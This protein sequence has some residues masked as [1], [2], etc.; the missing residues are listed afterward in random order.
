MQVLAK[1]IRIFVLI[2][3]LANA[4]SLAQET[5]KAGE[6]R[7]PIT[8]VAEDDFPRGV[9]RTRYWIDLAG[10]KIELHFDGHPPELTSGQIA[11]VR[12]V[13]RGKQIDAAL[14]SVTPAAASSSCG[15]IGEQKMAVL[16]IEFPGIPFPTSIVTATQ[17]H[18][19]YFSQTQFSLDGYWREASYGQTFATG[20]VFGPFLLDKNYDFFADQFGGLQA[21]INA[22]DSAV[23]FTV[24][25][26]VVV[27][28]PAPGVSGWGGRG[29]VGCLTL[30]SPTKGS[31][32]GTEAIM[33]VGTAQPYQGLVGLAAHEAG[34][35]LGLN[36]ASTLDYEPL[37]LGP[38]GMDGVHKEYGD[39]FSVMGGGEGGRVLGHYGAPHKYKLGWLDPS[40]VTNVETDGS[41]TLQPFEN[42]T[43]THTLRIQRGAGSTQW[44]WLEYRRPTGYDA[45]LSSI[46]AEEFAGA[47][48]HLEDPAEEPNHTYLLDFTPNTPHDFSDAAL[49]AGQVWSD[50][51]SPLSIRVDSADSSGLGVSVSYS[52]PCAT[53]NP[54]SRSHGS[55]AETGMFSVTASST[56]SWTAIS[57]IDWI[58]I[59]AGASGT[60]PGSVSYSLTA[61][62]TPS[63][64]TGS[65]FVGFEAFT[66]TQSTSFVSHPPSFDSLT[67]DT[68][69]GLSQ[70]FTFSISDPDGASDLAHIDVDFV[71]KDFICQF[72]YN[73]KDQQLYM[74][75][76]DLKTVIGPVTLPYEGALQN[77]QCGVDAS[78]ITVTSSGNSMQLTFPMVFLSA[79]N[80]SVQVNLY[81][82][83]KEHIG[84]IVGTWTTP[85]SSCSYALAPGAAAAVG[86]NE[87]AGT[88]A[89]G[90]AQGCPWL[91]SSDRSWIE[92]TSALSGAGGGAVSYTIGANATGVPRSGTITIAGQPIPVQQA[93]SAGTP[94]AITGVVNGASF[95]PGLASAAWITIDGTDLA[96]VTRSWTASDFAGN[97]LPR[98]LSGVSV[99]IDGQP[100]YVYYVSPTQLNVLAPDDSGTGTVSVEVDT[101]DG[102]SNQFMI[103][104]QPL[105]PALFLFDQ[106]GR[107]YAAAVYNDGTYVG[108]ANLIPGVTSRP[109]VPGDVILLFGT[110][111]GVTNPVASSAFLV[112]QPAPLSAPVTI[113]IGN[114]LANVAFAGLVASGLYQ[115]NVTVP[116]IPPGDQPV[117]IDIG[118]LQSQSNVNI[119]VGN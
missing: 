99:A 73:M 61:N 37:V 30:A 95:L 4:V 111:F 72:G 49:A 103:Q 16:M 96:P 13:R 23:D 63:A 53:L 20:D 34:H 90:V 44:L 67:P 11:A 51:Y 100:A 108:P 105:S 107:K 83:A 26:H 80:W 64:R 15:P 41:F 60:G 82:L 117:V 58:S 106:G 87:T 22:A 74:L 8:V 109:A 57:T 119:A 9:A 46:G 68:G 25:N 81:N 52:T 42:P 18:D 33:G 97:S 91:A 48:I 70:A 115:F 50:P 110:G 2:L 62:A 84:K 93:A 102:R 17:L 10:E 31:F 98:Q 55:G 79:G 3:T 43:G 47:L 69:S 112:A 29:S 28:W 85:A 24:Y 94:P 40:S 92:I 45:T 78:R 104:K 66:I 5:S 12:G 32:T 36:H 75:T 1:V 118:G 116:N 89:V 39:F 38:P 6:W 7:G 14:S 76:D 21:A 101:P 113:R 19:M 77:S 35:N 65:I 27:M 86:S 114:T 56:C 71:K 59:T 54:T 88:I